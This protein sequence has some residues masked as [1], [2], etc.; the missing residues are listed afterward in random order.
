[1]SESRKTRVLER[2]G[3]VPSFLGSDIDYTDE[4]QYSVSVQMYRIV[5]C[6]SVIGTIQRMYSGRR[7]VLIAEDAKPGSLI[8]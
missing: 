4:W 8:A 1:M 6:Y 2:F 5:L 7:R 3:L